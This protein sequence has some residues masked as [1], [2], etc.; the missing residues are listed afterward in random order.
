MMPAVF[1]HIRVKIKE[2]QKGYKISVDCLGKTI[3]K[4]HN[5]KEKE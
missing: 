2:P 1:A 3:G 4:A 5:K